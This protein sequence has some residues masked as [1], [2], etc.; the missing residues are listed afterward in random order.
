MTATRKLVHYFFSKN[1]FSTLDKILEAKNKDNDLPHI[2]I[3]SLCCVLTYL[4]FR[5]VLR[6]ISLLI[7]IEIKFIIL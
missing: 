7:E 5:Y 1:E 4:N 2:F 6:K 3:P